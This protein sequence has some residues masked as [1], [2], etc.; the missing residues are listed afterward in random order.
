MKPPDDDR[1][2]A[3]R[4]DQR[5]DVLITLDDGDEAEGDLCGKPESQTFR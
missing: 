5:P 1:F 2:R 3:Y 4:A